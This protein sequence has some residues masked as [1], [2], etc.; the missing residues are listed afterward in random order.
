MKC[1]KCNSEMGIRRG[2]FGE[3]YYCTK[4]NHGTIS[5]E[6]YE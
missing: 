3:F 4:G 2:K 1:L 6:K 5:V